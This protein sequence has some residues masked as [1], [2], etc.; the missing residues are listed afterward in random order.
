MTPARQLDQLT[1]QEGIMHASDIAVGVPTVTADDPV[2][3]AVRVLAVSR[4]PG[5]IVVDDR[6]RPRYVL[7]GTQV[8]RL[9]VPGPYLEDPALARAIDEDHADRFWEQA[10]SL[11]V[12][13]CVPRQPARPATVR[14]DATLLE[15][16]AL[17]AREHTPVVAVVDDTGA[18][19]GAITLER[20]ITSL[21]VLGPDE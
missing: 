5:L 14:A 20:L 8:L 6:Q 4:L 13:Q 18:L 15:T 16:A 21:A 17:M 3:R 12:G 2:A 1:G 9:A 7:P 11:T 19:T 10:G